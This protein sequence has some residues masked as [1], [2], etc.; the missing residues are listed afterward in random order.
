[1]LQSDKER[2]RDDTPPR[3]A[4]K[5][6]TS[7]GCR[8][9][10]PD[11]RFETT[12]DGMLDDPPP[13]LQLLKYLYLVPS[14]I[15]HRRLQLGKLIPLFSK[16]STELRLIIWTH[17]WP[18]PQMMEAAICQDETVQDEYKDVAILRLAGPL[19]TL[20]HDEHFGSRVVEQDPRV[21]CGPPVAL[22]VCHESRIYTLSQYQR[23]EHTAAKQGS[24]YFNPYRDVMWLSIDFTDE[25]N[26]LHDLKRCYGTPP[27]VLGLGHK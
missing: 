3:T 27:A 15:D 11:Q 10:V 23:I 19:S 13:D 14:I 4:K 21:R 1:M 7:S 5:P 6:A 2:G 12:L 17:T 20:L 26:Y 9:L 16:L 8:P 18:A 25:P 24:F 22:H